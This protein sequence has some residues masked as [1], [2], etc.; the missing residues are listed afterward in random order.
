VSEILIRRR[1]R[2]HGM[3]IGTA[4]SSSTSLPLDD[5]A[6][7]VVLLSTPSTSATLLRVYGSADDVT[8]GQVNDAGAAATITLSRQ[9]G[10]AVETVGTTTSTIT[11]YT[12]NAAAYALPDAAFGL[13]SVRLVADADLG[14]AANAH[15]V[16]KS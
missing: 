10:T 7:A 3:T 5:A 1:H 13:R 12:A 2:I 15:A 14:A 9:T 8:F 11:V 4:T 6:G 16:T